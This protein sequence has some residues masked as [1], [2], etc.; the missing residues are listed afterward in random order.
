MYGLVYLLED[1]RGDAALD[2][3]ARHE[4]A[5]QVPAQGLVRAACSTQGLF[6]F[7]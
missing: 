1:E 4:R 6:R 5:F 3:P 7:V 2:Q